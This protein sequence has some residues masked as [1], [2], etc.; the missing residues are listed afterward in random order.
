MDVLA[1]LICKNAE[2]FADESG[3]MHAV[4]AGQCRPLVESPMELLIAID[5]SMDPV[6]HKC[7]NEMGIFGLMERREQWAACNLSRCD[8]VPD[9]IYGQ[10]T[11]NREVVQCS[12]RASCNQEGKLC[13]TQEQQS[14]LTQRQLQV[15]A[16]TNQG[17]L[18]KEIASRMGI[19]EE[20]VKSHQQNIRIKTGAARKADLVRYAQKL[21]LISQ[22]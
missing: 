18:N 21:N 5:S 7:L 15:L 6:D 17:L 8:N 14:G 11:L 22:Q 13:R 20:T 3:K 1:G 16:F 2:V 10:E 4:M 19:S 9:Y 12:K